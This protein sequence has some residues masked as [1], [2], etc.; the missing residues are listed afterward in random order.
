MG[1]LD[2]R[3][4]IIRPPAFFHFV[5]NSA[6]NFIADDKKRKIVFA[7]N[8]NYLKVLSQYMDLDV[9]PA[10]IYP[11]G[12]NYD[13]AARG[14]PG[15]FCGGKISSKR[16][17][18]KRISRRNIQQQKQPSVRSTMGEKIRKSFTLCKKNSIRSKNQN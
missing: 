16:R 12:R 14:M 10:E 4:V 5:W 11:E 17:K 6:K 15:K 13:A 7:N 9:L 8:N 18:S 3:I 1:G 2:K